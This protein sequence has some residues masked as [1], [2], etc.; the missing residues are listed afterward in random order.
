M[1]TRLERKGKSRPTFYN[2]V[3][4]GGKEETKGPVDYS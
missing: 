2:V 4:D 3:V 1:C